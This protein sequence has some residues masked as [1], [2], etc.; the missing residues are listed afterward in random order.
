MTAILKVD[1]IQDTSGNNIINESSDTITI[2][3]SG[4]TTNIVGTLQNNGS[5]VA[6]TNGITEADQWRLTTSFSNS[7]D[8][9]VT[10]NWE[11]NDN[12]AFAKIG[13]GLSESS[14]VFS[15]PSTGLYYITWMVWGS[16]NGSSRYNYVRIDGTT[17]NSSYDG[18]S[19][20]SFGVLPISGSAGH[21]TGVTSCYFN[22]TD[23]STHKIKFK[24]N[25]E[26]SISINSQA[27]GQSNSPAAT[28]IRLG[29]AQ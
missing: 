8:N 29:D 4:D 7:G 23:V 24:I 28:F 12:T 16:Q 14:G 27:S 18:I 9:Y 1:T 17:N 2:G 22:V 19:W 3:A 13:T 5:A 20:T 26:N 21:A 15:F 25:T 11:R 6:S 10:S